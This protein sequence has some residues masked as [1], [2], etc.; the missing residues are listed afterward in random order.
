MMR[1]GYRADKVNF[2]YFG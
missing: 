2:G 1:I